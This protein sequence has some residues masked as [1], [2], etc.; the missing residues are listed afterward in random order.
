MVK[1]LQNRS[2][3]FQDLGMT[4]I[5]L[6]YRDLK[7]PF[8]FMTQFQTGNA[9]IF[10]NGRRFHFKV[11]ILIFGRMRTANL[12]KIIYE[13][14]EYFILQKSVIGAYT[15]SRADVN[16]PNLNCPY[17]RKSWKLNVSRVSRL[18]LDKL[19]ATNPEQSFTTYKVSPNEA[20]S[21][22]LSKTCTV[23]SIMSWAEI[24]EFG[25]QIT[26]YWILLKPDL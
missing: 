18:L 21:A 4:N 9:M 2:R 1:N 10:G 25:A 15:V 23:F 24:L 16:L 22:V 14:D 5:F 7:L 17:P 6:K 20:N 3:R 19:V 13:M 11:H 8:R 12:T 26:D